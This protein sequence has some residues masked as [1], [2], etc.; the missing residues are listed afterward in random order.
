MPGQLDPSHPGYW[1]TDVQLQQQLVQPAAVL[2]CFC[3]SVNFVLHVQNATASVTKLMLVG[4]LETFNF[5]I[6]R[7][8]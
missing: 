2:I 7:L 6:Y 4:G 8:F 5:S 1:P 3:V